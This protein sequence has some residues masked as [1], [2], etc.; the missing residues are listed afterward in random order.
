[1][2]ATTWPFGVL[3]LVSDLCFLF[4][5]PSVC[6]LVLQPGI[7]ST[8][9]SLLPETAVRLCLHFA[10]LGALGECAPGAFCPSS[11]ALLRKA[12]FGSVLFLVGL[13]TGGSVQHWCSAAWQVSSLLRC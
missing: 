13:V 6:Q 10:Q 12:C 7:C 2:R 11:C 1:M 3:A 8:C 9:S 4:C 5:L